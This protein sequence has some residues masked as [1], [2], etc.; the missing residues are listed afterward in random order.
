M[1]KNGLTYLFWHN[2]IIHLLINSWSES[3]KYLEQAF[4]VVLVR[5]VLLSLNMF[6]LTDMV[7]SKG[8]LKCLEQLSHDI[9]FLFFWYTFFFTQIHRDVKKKSSQILKSNFSFEIYKRFSLVY[10]SN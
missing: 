9:F 3:A 8:S 2:R 7:L 5:V 1:L 4:V 6:L 10:A